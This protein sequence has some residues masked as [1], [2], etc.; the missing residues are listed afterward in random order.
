[1]RSRASGFTLIEI[2]VF[3]IVS[4]LLMSVVLIGAVTAL[5]SS[6]SVHQQ[7]I[8]VQTARKCME[9]YLDQ[10]L[11]NGYAALS[12]PSTP[13]AGLCTAPA[14]FNASA[15]V[16]CTT[17]NGDSAYKTITVNVTGLA[18]ASLSAQVGDF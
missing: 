5:R 15:S 7:W 6:P 10:R 1:M 12:C 17:W 14:D 4:S 3:I 13:A 9:W 18:S 8:A 11:L 16:S 2:L